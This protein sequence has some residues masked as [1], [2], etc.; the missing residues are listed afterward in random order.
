[1]ICAACGLPLVQRPNELD[2]S[3]YRRL[4]CNM[5]CASRKRAV[6]FKNRHGQAGPWLKLGTRGGGRSDKQ[7][8]NLVAAAIERLAARKAGTA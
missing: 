2:Y 5:K 4:T 6:A 1:M 3:F 8:R 7:R